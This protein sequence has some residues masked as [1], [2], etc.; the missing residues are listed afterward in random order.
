DSV[1]KTAGVFPHGAGVEHAGKAVAS[2]HVLNLPREFG[3]RNG[4]YISPFSFE[5]VHVAVPQAGGDG[6][7]ETI[8]D[9]SGFGELHLRS[10]ADGHDLFALD[11]HNA[12]A[13][14]L[15]RGTDKNCG[16]YKRGIFG[17]GVCWR[18]QKKFISSMVPKR[19]ILAQTLVKRWRRGFEAEW[20]EAS[21]S[22]R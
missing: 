13:D 5:E 21:V 1:A 19:D 2:Q 3:R 15:F 7:A 18:A 16:A 22:R 8:E 4:A 17:W 6:E 11:E 12:V 10:A 20:G 14:G 9:M